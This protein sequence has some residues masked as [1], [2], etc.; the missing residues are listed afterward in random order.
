[1][2][3][4][5]VVLMPVAQ[6]ARSVAVAIGVIIAVFAAWGG[7]W[8]QGIPYSGQDVTPVY[9]GWQENPDGTFDLLFGYFNRNMQEELDV[10]VG[11]DN[12]IE[13]GGLD[14]GQPTHFYPQ[15]SRFVFYVRVPE[16][17]GDQEVVWT[18]TSHGKTN[19]A[20]GTLHPDYY[21]DNIVIMNNQ[22]AGGAGGGANFINDNVAPTLR[23]E[24]PPLRS[25]AVGETVTLAAV[26]TDDGVPKRRT[27]PLV[28]PWDEEWDAR[29]SRIG[30]RCCPDSASGL[31][32]S[33][34]VYRGRAA[35]VTFDPPQF[36]HWE[37]YR[38]GRN[39]PWSA[40]WEVPPI[41]EDN[42]WTDAT[43][44]FSEPGTYVLRTL[45]HDGG[46]MTSEDVTFI[47]K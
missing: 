30:Q 17:F 34:F 38:D 1:M 21:A 33:W 18:L 13:P 25:V 23:V 27:I 6:N 45:A 35:A 11:P 43:V 46:L 14:R 40:G 36:E 42:R 31:R 24:G 16:D 2:D 12:R 4:R 3:R 10:P 37:D 5:N 28:L 7:V 44:T 26:A 22:G 9:E 20:Y 19:T 32:L 41:P 8:A 15:R 39:S 29:R 47:V